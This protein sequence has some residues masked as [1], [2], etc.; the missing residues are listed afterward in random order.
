MGL[1]DAFKK[2]AK[3]EQQAIKTTNKEVERCNIC[4]KKA[5]KD[6]L[7]GLMDGFLNIWE[8]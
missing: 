7:R 5:T 3:K 6:I 2:K 1:F 4:G 8:A